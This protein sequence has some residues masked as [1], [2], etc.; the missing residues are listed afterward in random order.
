MIDYVNSN[1]W[2]DHNFKNQFDWAH[3]LM[4]IVCN[5]NKSIQIKSIQIKRWGTKK[6]D[7]V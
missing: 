1:N 4:I 2:I 5:Q 3:D 7:N 6:I